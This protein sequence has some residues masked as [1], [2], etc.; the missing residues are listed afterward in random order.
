MNYEKHAYLILAHTNPGQLLNLFRVLDHPRN[1]IYVHIDRK[2]SFR[3]EDFSGC[4]RH[5]GLHF[6][7][8]RIAVHWGGISIMRAELALLR[9]AAPGHYAYYHLLSGQ[10]LPIKSQDEIHAF[11]DAHPDRE[12]LN[13]WPFKSHTQN[14][15]RYYTVF[16]EGAGSFLPNLA[17]NIVKGILMALHIQINRDIEFHFASQWFSISHPCAEYVLSQE[18]WLEKVFKH[19][20]T[21]DEVFL[22]TVICNSPFRERLF[23]ASEH[24][25]NEDIFNQASMRFIDWTR[26][27][28]VRHPWVFRIT[29]KA[30]LESVP[31]LWARKFD[32]RVDTDIIDYFCEKYRSDSPQAPSVP[33]DADIPA[34]QPESARHGFARDLRHARRSLLWQGELLNPLWDSREKRRAKR[35]TIIVRHVTDFR[36]KHVLHA[37]DAVAPQETVRDDAG[38]KIY[39]IWLQGEQNAP[40]IVKSCL[41]SIRAHCKQELVVLDE[42]TLPDYISLPEDILRKYRA[43]K[44]KPSHFSDIC[45]VELLYRHGGYWLDATTFATGPIPESITEQDFF[46]FMAGQHIYGNYSYI[47]NCF[48]RARKGSWLLAAWRAMILDYWHSADRRIEYFQHQLM[49]KTLVENHPYAAELFAQMPKIDQDPT[50][51]LFFIHGDEPFDPA[52]QEQITREGFFFQKTTYKSAKTPVPGSFRAYQTFW[53]KNSSQINDK[54]EHDA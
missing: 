53:Y 22:A 15:F 9:A 32:E 23:D 44:I 29:D 41:A 1:D 30:L 48:I 4:C 28:S 47:Q 17:N 46:V 2:A 10:D 21:A 37:A 6:L 11:F 43:G 52:L 49:F 14:R 45:R 50:H 12:F 8:P 38:E 5:S 35:S 36:R 13:L 27:E 54:Y 33:A 16:P 39:T 19:T 42:K 18:A 24:V 25:Q 20:N 34:P 40:D 7:E 51:Y 3:P 26:G 31:H